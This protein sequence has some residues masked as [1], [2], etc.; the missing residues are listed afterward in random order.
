MQKTGVS[1]VPARM[2]AWLKPLLPNE[3]RIL[4]FAA[5]DVL[6]KRFLQPVLPE[7]EAYF[8]LIRQHL[9]PLLQQNCPV[10][11]GKPYPL[12]QCLEI[13]SAFDQVLQSQLASKQPDEPEALR[14]LQ[15]FKLAGGDIRQVWGDLRGQ[16]F[17]NAFQ[18]GTLYIDVANDTVVPTKPKVEILPFQDAQFIAIQD[19]VHFRKLAQCYWG[20]DIYPNHVLPALAPCCPFVHITKS[21]RIRVHE[22]TKYMVAMTSSQAY[23]PSEAVLAEPAM[24]KEVFDRVRH[25][26]QETGLVT[27]NDPQTGRQRAIQQCREQR[28][29]RWHQ[30]NSRLNKAVSEVWKINQIL[31]KLPTL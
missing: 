23:R 5:Q 9:D 7:L 14:A 31:A 30:D 18:F 26:L 6:T 2:G 1:Q 25:G 17:Q 15:A 16:Y 24:P 11:S 28:A 19:F 13:A 21:G 4:D 3:P 10:K 8:L 20:D 22:A 12:G 29:K 27:V